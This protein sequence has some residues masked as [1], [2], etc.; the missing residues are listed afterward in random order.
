MTGAPDSAAWMIFGVTMLL[1][2]VVVLAA[3]FVVLLCTTALGSR[4][5]QRASRPYLVVK[6]VWTRDPYRRPQDH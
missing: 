4:V 2:T 6:E 3:G 1:G 5:W